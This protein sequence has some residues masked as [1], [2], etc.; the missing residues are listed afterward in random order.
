MARPRK[1]AATSTD[2]STATAGAG[3][4]EPRPK[5]PRKGGPRECPS[6]RSS[7]FRGVTRHRWT[8]RFEAHLWDKHTWNESQSKKGRQGITNHSTNPP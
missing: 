4:V 8:G 1:T 2:D 7:A 6:Q 5:R 3:R